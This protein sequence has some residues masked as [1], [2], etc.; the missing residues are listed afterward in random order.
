MTG[1][2]EIVASM[3]PDWLQL[4]GGETP[5]RAADVKA[6]YGLPVMKAFAIR[7][8]SDLTRANPITALPTGCCSTP[9]RRKDPIFRAA[10]G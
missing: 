7:D 6:R 9:S 4:H 3:K 2:D 5:E 8:A 1:L 10:T